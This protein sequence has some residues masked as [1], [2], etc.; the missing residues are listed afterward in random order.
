ML[1]EKE[2]KTAVKK[3]NKLQQKGSI[4]REILVYVCDKWVNNPCFVGIKQVLEESE[5]KLISALTFA[6]T[7]RGNTILMLKYGIHVHHNLNTNHT[8]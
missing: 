5:I 2:L 4:S 7:L 3:V 1:I 6:H 8:Y